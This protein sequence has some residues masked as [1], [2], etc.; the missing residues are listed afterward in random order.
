M[1]LLRDKRDDERPLETPT[2]NSLSEDQFQQ[3]G[4][5]VDERPAEKGNTSKNTFST[6][7]IAAAI[8]IIAILVTY[9]GFY[10]PK[11]GGRTVDAPTTMVDNDSTAISE[12]DDN[13]FPAATTDNFDVTTTETSTS[14]QTAGE[15]S[16]LTASK[17]MQNIQ[18]A[19]GSGR[20]TAFFS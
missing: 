20:V 8:F 5:G 15:S 14:S 9:F 2:D 6:L 17:V 18:T 7:L 4:S 1:N 13:S 11:E 19:I 10:K 3:A 16:L 12:T